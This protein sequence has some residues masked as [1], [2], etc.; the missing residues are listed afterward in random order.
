VI[1]VK[2]P[3]GDI[4]RVDLVIPAED[5]AGEQHEQQEEK[6]DSGNSAVNDHVGSGLT[7]HPAGVDVNVGAR[8]GMDEAQPVAGRLLA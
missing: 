6:A 8:R 2:M 5:L 4:V 3:G 1:A 7:L